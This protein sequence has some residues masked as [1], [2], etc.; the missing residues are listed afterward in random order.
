MKKNLKPTAIITFHK[1]GKNTFDNELLKRKK[2]TM[3]RLTKKGTSY[4][5]KTIVSDLILSPGQTQLRFFK[6]SKDGENRNYT[7]STNPIESQLGG[8]FQSFSAQFFAPGYKNLIIKPSTYNIVEAYSIIRNSGIV[9]FKRTEIIVHECMLSEILPEAPMLFLPE[10]S[11]PIGT[12]TVTGFKPAI[13]AA[14]PIPM[15]YSKSSALIQYFPET[16]I[17]RQG[18][19]MDL[20]ISFLNNISVPAELSGGYIFRM[21]LKTSVFAEKSKTAAK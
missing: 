1:I 14:L 3:K 4:S 18:E 16:L 5:D 6:E 8:A 11:A 21:A 20:D 10:D 13:T 15:S 17:F 2:H 19:K 7:G 9:T 12:P